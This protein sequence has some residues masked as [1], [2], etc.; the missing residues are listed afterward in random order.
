MRL[1]VPDTL[2]KFRDRRLNRSPEIRPEAVGDGILDRFTNFHKSPQE[3]AGDI[4]SG[5][6]VEL[7]G[8]DALAKFGDSRLNIDRVIR[9]FARVFSCQNRVGRV[10]PTH[11]CSR[12][13][14][15]ND[16]MCGRFMWPIVSDNLVKFHD[17]GLNRSRDIRPL[18][19]FDNR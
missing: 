13:E 9:L 2:V 1:T 11:F 6:A 19:N 4:I 17:P 12:Q 10:C 5:L 3:L 15:T 8:M 14:T 16:V 18:L 7:V